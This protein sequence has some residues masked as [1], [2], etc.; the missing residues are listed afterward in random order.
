MVLSPGIPEGWDEDWALPVLQREEMEA[1]MDWEHKEF[2]EGNG[3]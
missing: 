2:E 3:I 1:G